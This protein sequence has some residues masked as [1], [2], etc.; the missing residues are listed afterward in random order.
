MS[1]VQ[2]ATLPGQYDAMLAIASQ[3]ASQPH[4]VYFIGRAERV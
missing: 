4:W 3:L 1:M 2:M